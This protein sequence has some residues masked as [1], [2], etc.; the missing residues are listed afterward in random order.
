MEEYKYAPCTEIL[1]ELNDKEGNTW[2]K[3]NDPS[4]GEYFFNPKT[5]EARWESP[6]VVAPA[7]GS[8]QFSGEPRKQL[9]AIEEILAGEGVVRSDSFEAVKFYVRRSKEMQ[10]LANDKLTTLRQELQLKSQSLEKTDEAKRRSVSFAEG[11]GSQHLDALSARHLAMVKAHDEAQDVIQKL[12]KE[13]ALADKHNQVLRTKVVANE[14]NLQDV[15]KEIQIANTTGARKMHHQ[16]QEM[17]Y[18]CDAERT[19]RVEMARELSLLQSLYNKETKRK[20]A[21][22]AEKE[23]MDERARLQ[24][25]IQDLRTELQQQRLAAKQSKQLALQGVAKVKELQNELA[26]QVRSPTKEKLLHSREELVMH[27]APDRTAG[28]PETSAVSAAMVPVDLASESFESTIRALKE[29]VVASNEEVQELGMKARQLSQEANIQSRAGRKLAAER[30]QLHMLVRQAVDWLIG[31]GAD[32]KAQ[33]LTVVAQKL[34][35]E[36]PQKLPAQERMLRRP[37]A[38]IR[39]ESIGGNNANDFREEGFGEEQL[40][41]ALAKVTS[42]L[43]NEQKQTALLYSRENEAR[44]KIETLQQEIY[45]G[46][47]VDAERNERNQNESSERDYQTTVA[48]NTPCPEFDDR[49]KAIFVRYKEA[50][51]A[52]ETEV[53]AAKERE[54]DGLRKVGELKAELELQTRAS[55]LTTTQHQN[56]LEELRE[57]FKRRLGSAHHA[58][59]HAELLKLLKVNQIDDAWGMGEDRVEKPVPVQTKSIELESDAAVQSQL[60]DLDNELKMAALREQAG[61]EKIQM[62]EGELRLQLRAI[63]TAA[64]RGT[65]LPRYHE[66][67]HQEEQDVRVVKITAVGSQSRVDEEQTKRV[68]RLMLAESI[69]ASIESAAMVARPDA[70]TV[71]EAPASLDDAIARNISLQELEELDMTVGLVGA[72]GTTAAEGQRSAKEDGGVLLQVRCRLRELG[73]KVLELMQREGELTRVVGEFTSELNLQEQHTLLCADKDVQKVRRM[74]AVLHEMKEWVDEG[75]FPVEISERLLGNLT[76]VSVELECLYCMQIRKHKDNSRTSGGARG[77][78]RREDSSSAGDQGRARSDRGRSRNQASEKLQQE[79]EQLREQVAQLKVREA[80]GVDRC[81]QLSR[82]LELMAQTPEETKQREAERN[83]HYVLSQLQQW[84]AES[85]TLEKLQELEYQLARA[86]AKAATLEEQELDRDAEDQQER[87]SALDPEQELRSTV[88]LPLERELSLLQEETAG[89]KARETE[90]AEKIGSMGR[91][92]EL[93]AVQLQLA[94]A[95]EEEQVVRTA[96]LRQALEAKDAEHAELRAAAAQWEQLHRQVMAQQQQAQQQQHAWHSSRDRGREEGAAAAVV[97]RLRAEL[98][99]A[100]AGQLEQMAKVSAL[101]VQA[102]SDMMGATDQRLLGL[103]DGSEGSSKSTSSSAGRHAHRRLVQKQE[104]KA[105]QTPVGVG[106]SAVLL[107]SGCQKQQSRVAQPPSAA[108]G[109]PS[110][111]YPDAYTT[112]D[113]HAAPRSPLAYANSTSRTALGQNNDLVD[114]LF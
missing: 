46:A 72:I 79:L 86:R 112:R 80:D 111:S 90:G 35:I 27:R 109:R 56:K 15:T 94:Q 51:T 62:L 18:Q 87:P 106:L 5:H 57:F 67:T 48:R 108:S 11:E 28:A 17:G 99:K 21:Q 107:P 82:E 75:Q 22:G 26:I 16:L 61:L 10:Q 58:V 98:T 84:A 52:L 63:E 47:R 40:V 78:K 41:E 100:K 14:L 43:A 8:I 38:D 53:E 97:E 29:E 93:L 92:V 54:T 59:H 105:A 24:S 39:V 114:D 89:L 104:M 30:E 81:K 50:V 25:T 76:R 37:E 19:L 95:K 103:G 1:A 23:A 49:G 42:A 9:D 20:I 77:G 2:H 13:L 88:I 34:A 70:P 69:T 12:K 96:Q 65:S 91:E 74:N 110:S 68:L 3:I 113:Y 31:V 7:T 33:Y 64:V 44:R 102:A 71:K 73:A 55:F 45:I 85:L 32:K 4:S 36:S 83:A 66:Q 60:E 101:E 6:V